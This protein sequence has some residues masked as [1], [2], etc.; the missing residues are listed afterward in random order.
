MSAGDAVTRRRNIVK[1]LIRNMQITDEGWTF[2]DA[3]RFIVKSYG[4]GIR[5]STATNILRQLE[6]HKVIYRKRGLLYA[7]K[8]RNVDQ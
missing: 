6:R 1:S 2:D 5:D 7:K 3:L 8:T 4:H